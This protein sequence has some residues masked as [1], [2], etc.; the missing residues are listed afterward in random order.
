MPQQSVIVSTCPTKIAITHDT[1]KGSYD[2]V[3]LDVH[4]DRIDGISSSCIIVKRLQHVED[5]YL[6]NVKLTCA[7]SMWE[8]TEDILL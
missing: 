4:L 5:L 6:Y 3:E 8:V 2:F 1:E 7:R